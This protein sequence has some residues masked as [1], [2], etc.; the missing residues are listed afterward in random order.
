MNEKNGVLETKK[1]GRREYLLEKCH[2][3]KIGEWYE[4]S[5]YNAIGIREQINTFKTLEESKAYFDDLRSHLKT[6]KEYRK[7]G[8]F[9]PL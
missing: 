8:C 5:T 9:P 2:N 3:K 7:M 6:A 1:I 4:I